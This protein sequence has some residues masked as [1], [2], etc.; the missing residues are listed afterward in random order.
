MRK[1]K[2]RGGDGNLASDA[3]AACLFISRINA[4][5]SRSFARIERKHP[6]SSRWLQT[7][8]GGVGGDLHGPARRVNLTNENG[9]ALNVADRRTLLMSRPIYSIKRVAECSAGFKARVTG[10]AIMFLI[11][12]LAAGPA[13]GALP[14]VGR[15][16]RRSAPLAAPSHRHQTHCPTTSRPRCTP[17]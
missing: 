17:D 8:R 12:W 6:L 5:D 16:S 13:P 1:V 4:E 2:K 14:L 15:S 11:S 9:S 10:A 3:A 7:N